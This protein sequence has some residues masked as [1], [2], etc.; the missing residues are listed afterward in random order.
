MGESSKINR[1]TFRFTDYISTASF[2][3]LAF[4]SVEMS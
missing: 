2:F 3:V 4:L 1:G